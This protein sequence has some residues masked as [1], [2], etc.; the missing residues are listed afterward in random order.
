MILVRGDEYAD[1]VGI[2]LSECKRGVWSASSAYIYNIVS[3]FF[4][5]IPI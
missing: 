3:I 4:S 1:V 2:G 5:I